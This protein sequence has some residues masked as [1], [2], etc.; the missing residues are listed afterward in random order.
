MLARIQEANSLTSLGNS[1]WV[2][3]GAMG[4]L[5]EYGGNPI[6][7]FYKNGTGHFFSL[8]STPPYGYISEGL[9]GYSAP[10]AGPI[11]PNNFGVS[12]YR[13]ARIKGGSGHVYTNNYA[14]L[15]GGNASWLYEGVAFYFFLKAVPD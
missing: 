10:N 13:Y 3:E 11:I 7:R 14:E 8:N 12:I 1:P 2:N 6:Y 5:R 4:L 9:I 15:G